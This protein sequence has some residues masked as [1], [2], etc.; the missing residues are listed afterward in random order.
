MP[1]AGHHQGHIRARGAD[2]FHWSVVVPEQS[3]TVAAGHT[4]TSHGRGGSP[5]W[6]S[7]PTSRTGPI[8][9]S[10]KVAMAEAKLARLFWEALDRVAYALTFARLS[11]FDVIHGPEPPT[12]A[13]EKRQADRVLPPDASRCGAG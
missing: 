8:C 5:R 13:D 6:L 9:P 4:E 10:S 1:G 11:L 2:R 12:L 7:A 3:H